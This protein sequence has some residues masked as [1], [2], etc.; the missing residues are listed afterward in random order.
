MSFQVFT[1]DIEIARTSGRGRTL[2][3]G[4][5]FLLWARIGHPIIE[6]TIA[7]K[8]RFDGVALQT[9]FPVFGCG[10]GQCLGRR[11]NQLHRS[12]FWAATSYT[13]RSRSLERRDMGSTVSAGKRF[14][15]RPASSRRSNGQSA[16]TL[17]HRDH[18]ERSIGTDEPS[19]RANLTKQVER[20][21]QL[22]S[23]VGA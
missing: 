9:L 21:G 6:A 4:M 16:Q 1:P 11:M 19:R 2:A 23:I 17:A 20:R 14:R 15:V 7:E 5:G 13:R 10:G 22:Q 12:C 8:R 18:G 3:S